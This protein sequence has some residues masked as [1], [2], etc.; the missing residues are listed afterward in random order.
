MKASEIVKNTFFAVHH[1]ITV[2]C[3][4]NFVAKLFPEYHHG[5]T[6]EV[7]LIKARSSIARKLRLLFLKCFRYPNLG[8][9]AVSVPQFIDAV[10]ILI[11][12]RGVSLTCFSRFWF[13]KFTRGSNMVCWREW[14]KLGKKKEEHTARHRAEIGGNQSSN[15]AL[16]TG[17]CRRYFQALPDWTVKTFGIGEIT[18]NK[19]LLLFSG[20]HVCKPTTHGKYQVS[21]LNFATLKSVFSCLCNYRVNIWVMMGAGIPGEWPAPAF[22]CSRNDNSWHP[23][24]VPAIS[25]LERSY[26]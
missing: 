7:W 15:L 20:C 3:S 17:H 16:V 21:G 26:R 5:I 24:L 19:M 6:Q 12:V 22:C 1:S 11:G 9:M 8:D 2:D 23:S 14:Q 18:K 10:R 25:A 4:F 13:A